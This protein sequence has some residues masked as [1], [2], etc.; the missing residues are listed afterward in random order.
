MSA[1]NTISTENF[2][3]S[4]GGQTPSG[5]LVLSRRD[6]AKLMDHAAWLKSVEIGFRAVAEGN[7][8]APPP[9]AIDGW[10]GAFH[11]KGTG[12][13][14][15]RRYVALKLNGN[16]PSNHEARGLPTIQGA[17]LLCDGET[18]SLLAIMD[19]IE[20]TLRRTAAATA[21][22]A[23]YLARPESETILICGCGARRARPNSMLCTACSR[24]GASLPGTET[25]PEPRGSPKPRAGRDLKSRLLLTLPPPVLAT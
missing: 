20:V 7:A 11:A 4:I 17:I 15:G 21:L 16:F 10:G 8:F 13:A 5:T 3:N 25:P 12:M 18:R 24:S 19:S 6:V 14:L 22:V 2:S 1:I 23:R 9:M